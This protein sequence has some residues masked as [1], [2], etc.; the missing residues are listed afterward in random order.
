MPKDAR[1]GRESPPP[2]GV[3]TL[4]E[5]CRRP[6]RSPA[7]PPRSAPSAAITAIYFQ[8][9]LV[10]PTTVALT[11]VLAV[12]I[13]AG[14]WGIVEATAAAVIAVLCFNFFFLPPIGT[15]TIAD[16]QNWV[17]LFV[18]MVTAIVVS[19]LSG[20]ARQRNL[21]AL[22]RQG[23][24]ERLYALSRSLLLAESGGAGAS[25]AQHIAEAFRASGR[26]GCTSSRPASSP[27]SGPID[28]ARLTT[29]F[30]RWPA[31]ACRCRTDPACSSPPFDWE[32]HRSAAWP[33]PAAS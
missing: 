13:I 5:E 22:A 14:S 6:C 19:Q 25:I 27:A 24:L 30:A 1:R 31:G 3:V 16:P 21:E 29:V 26:R 12:L 2:T 20:R 9:V 17:A 18:L 33:L 28:S 32:A 8:Y 4:T 10:N 15:W 11:Y 23:D 7:L